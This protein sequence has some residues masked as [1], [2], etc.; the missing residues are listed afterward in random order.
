MT[1]E[2][3][4]VS[5]IHG[6]DFSRELSPGRRSVISERAEEKPSVEEEQIS[7]QRSGGH[8]K[9]EREQTFE[10]ITEQLEREEHFK[11]QLPPIQQRVIGYLA[12][13]KLKLIILEIHYQETENRRS[14]IDRRIDRISTR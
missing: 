11:H 8:V 4:P 7:A 6:G 14:K 2:S 5:S 10:E 3:R 1:H 12:N 9:F 13:L